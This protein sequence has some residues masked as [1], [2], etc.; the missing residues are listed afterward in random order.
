M[1][2]EK[3]KIIKV[4]KSKDEKIKERERAMEDHKKQNVLDEF[5]KSF[6]NFYRCNKIS[7]G[8]V[9]VMIFL[10]Y[11][12]MLFH[13]SFS[14]DTEEMVEKQMNFYDGWIGVNR[15]GLIFTKW[16]AGVLSIVPGFATI[17]MVL[18][19]AGYSLMWMYFFYWI[20]G[21]TKKGTGFEW[22]FPV[23]FF[24]SFSVI[25]LTNFQCLSFEV[26]VAMF[27]CSAAL[28]L[29]WQWILD[30]GGKVK[31]AVFILLGVW[32]FAS[33]QAFVPVYISASLVSFVLGY[34]YGNE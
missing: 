34:Q 26:A 16:I 7:I 32:C 13:F 3:Y 25:E 28:I 14:I 33:Y 29:E 9:M 1:V 27:I 23:L 5:V 15:Y 22:V 24:S 12:F 20:K 6:A 17:L 10:A 18:A 31:A 21:E 30:G 19:T 11:G 4:K 2:I 8:I